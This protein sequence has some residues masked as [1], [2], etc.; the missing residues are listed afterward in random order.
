MIPVIADVLNIIQN[1][2]YAF[3][4]T[5]VG[6]TEKKTGLNHIWWRLFQNV[7]QE[8]ILIKFQDVSTLVS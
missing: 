6:N 7:R 8:R 1:I 3:G 4:V 5:N 2:M